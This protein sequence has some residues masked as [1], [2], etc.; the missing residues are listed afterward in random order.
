M[1]KIQELV[2]KRSYIKGRITR[3]KN[4][5]A[6]DETLIA[7]SIKMNKIEEYH[8]EYMLVQ[9]ELM[10]LSQYDENYE[11]DAAEV[12]DTLIELKRKHVTRSKNTTSKRRLK[13]NENFLTR[14][15]KTNKHCTTYLSINF[16]AI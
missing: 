10:E 5:I 2:K 11:L 4:Q 15:Q 9:N 7:F 14:A 6:A 1:A 3:V 16:M 8:L 12:E 13:K